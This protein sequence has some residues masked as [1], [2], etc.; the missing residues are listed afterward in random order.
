MSMNRKF[1]IIV[2][3]LAMVFVA[4]SCNKTAVQ[5]SPQV[6]T[7]EPELAKIQVYETV[8]G[9]NLNKPDY[10]VHEGVAAL[11]LLKGTH[12]VQT[13]EYS[14]LG[15]FVESI[16]GTK[17]DKNHFWSFYVNGKQAEVGAGAYVLKNGDRIEWKLEKI[18]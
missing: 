1:R 14:G 15:E 10:E 18:K 4:A 6:Q 8:E 5:N 17:P 2:L 3:A 13:K 11:A 7:Q 9:S 12:T 16:D